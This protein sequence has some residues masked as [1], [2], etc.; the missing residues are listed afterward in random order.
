MS[1]LVWGAAALLVLA[2]GGLAARYTFWRPDVA[3]V[4]V[5]MYHYLADDVSA[6]NLPKLWVR[7][8]A[9]ARQ[10]DWLRAHGYRSI[11][12]AD[13]V[14][15]FEDGRP[16]PERPV[17]ITFDDGARESVFVAQKIMGE[18]GF[19]GVVFAVSGQVGETNLWD[20]PK[21]EPQTRLLDWGELAGLAA[22]G[23]DIGS[24]TRSHA[25][26]T[27]LDDQALEAELAGAKADLEK[28]LG[29]E[30][31][32]LA[33]PYGRTDE[34]VRRASAEAGYRLAL[35]TAWG[36]NQVTDDPLNL[37]RII[38]KRKDGLWDLA[39]KMKKGRSTL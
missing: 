35:T 9:F 5:L 12:V 28:Q 19:S 30:I 15:F 13:L 18:R 26:L 38:I 33:Y 16:L 7:P 25:E 36:K 10:M 3:G 34:R 17:M 4:P 32:I 23:W 6:T 22:A 29:L 2:A 31:V 39:L 1:A 8:G 27:E 14:G 21:G 24:H 20:A 37:K 11:G